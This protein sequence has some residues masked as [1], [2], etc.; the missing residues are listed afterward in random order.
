VICKCGEEMEWYAGD[1]AWN[2]AISGHARIPVEP[3]AGYSDHKC[4][5]CGLHH[6]SSFKKGEESV[7]YWYRYGAKGIIKVDE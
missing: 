7:E 5:A 4:D 6:H 1:V 2:Y 3:V